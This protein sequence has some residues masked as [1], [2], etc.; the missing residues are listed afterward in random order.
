M[1]GREFLVAAADVEWLQASGN[2][3]NLRVRGHDYP[4]RSTLAAMRVCTSRTRP[5]CLAGGVTGM[6]SERASGPQADGVRGCAV[7]ALAC[8]EFVLAHVTR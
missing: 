3:V 5:C 4:L 6:R 2:Y 1:L 8:I 7:R